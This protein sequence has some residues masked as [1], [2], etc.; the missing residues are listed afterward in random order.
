MSESA[1]KNTSI[2]NPKLNRIKVKKMFYVRHVALSTNM[3]FVYF[4]A[5]WAK[6]LGGQVSVQYTGETHV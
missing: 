4:R 5:L 1:G 3:I 6:Q 2:R